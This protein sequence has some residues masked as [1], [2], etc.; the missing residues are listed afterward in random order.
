MEKS[1][2]YIRHKRGI[3]NFSYTG[4]LEDAIKKAEI[5]LEKVCNDSDFAKWDW[6]YNLAKKKVD[7]H[8]LKISDLEAFIRS[9]KKQLEKESK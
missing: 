3:A 9:A 2:Y 6:L 4:N 1:K 7:A 5:D 8:F